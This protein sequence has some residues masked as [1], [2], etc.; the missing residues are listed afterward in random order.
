MAVTT[1]KI[2]YLT[3]SF[4]WA[5]FSSE[6]DLSDRKIIFT[7]NSYRYRVVISKGHYNLT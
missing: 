1:E 3:F 2:G 5:N 6:S 4:S 7:V